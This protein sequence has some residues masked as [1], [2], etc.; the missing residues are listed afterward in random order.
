MVTALAAGGATGGITT[1]GLGV[2]FLQENAKLTKQS[3]RRLP[4]TDLHPPVKGIC[5]KIWFVFL[6]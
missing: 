2:S 4:E 5:N 6:M 3:S 1:E